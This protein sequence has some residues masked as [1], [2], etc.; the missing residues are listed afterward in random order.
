MWL[1]LPARSTSYFAFSLP[2]SGCCSSYSSGKILFECAW[3]LCFLIGLFFST[4]LF[5]FLLFC[6]HFLVPAL[7]SLLQQRQE[8]TIYLRSASQVVIEW[9][10]SSLEVER[11]LQRALFFLFFLTLVIFRRSSFNRF[12]GARNINVISY[13]QFWEGLNTLNLKQSDAD[14]AQLEEIRQ[15]D[16]VYLKNVKGCIKRPGHVLILLV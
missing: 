7:P 8:T 10:M 13:D 9:W 14:F 1:R 11:L 15:L 3:L 2:L 16:D 6:L 12:S 5:L 4:T